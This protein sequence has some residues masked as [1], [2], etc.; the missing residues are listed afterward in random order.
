MLF[1]LKPRH[2]KKRGVI[3][4]AVD[5][6]QPDWLRG[7]LIAIVTNDNKPA[8]FGGQNAAFIVCRYSAPISIGAAKRARLFV[9]YRVSAEYNPTETG[10]KRRGLENCKVAFDVDVVVSFFEND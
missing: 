7:R 8:Y 2:N 5:I 9:V 3:Q 10:I 6:N 1:V 4:P